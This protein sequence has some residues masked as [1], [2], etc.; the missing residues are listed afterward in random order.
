[1]GTVKV[2]VGAEGETVLEW[3]HGDDATLRF[4]FFSDDP[5]TTPIDVSGY[6]HHMACA[7]AGGSDDTWS[8]T[9]DE[10]NAASGYIDVTTP[11]DDDLPFRGEW[12]LRRVD[13]SGNVLTLQKGTFSALSTVTVIP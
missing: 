6:T 11:S 10:S 1:M 9:I 7:E 5:P 12:D 2:N 4:S 3:N 13:G 8:F